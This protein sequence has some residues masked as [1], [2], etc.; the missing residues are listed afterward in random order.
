MNGEIEF[1]VTLMQM[2]VGRFS[3]D[4]QW[5][6]TVFATIALKS[7]SFNSKDANIADFLQDSP[8]LPLTSSEVFFF[9]FIF[10]YSYLYRKDFLFGFVC[11]YNQYSKY[12]TQSILN[13]FILYD[14]LFFE[15]ARWTV[16]IFVTDHFTAQFLLF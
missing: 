4:L 13:N 8:L 10:N 6:I 15:A 7:A 14:A 16:L 5:T 12:K 11:C 9:D 3:L 1:I 2:H